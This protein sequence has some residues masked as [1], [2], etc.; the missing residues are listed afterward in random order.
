MAQS[1]PNPVP[2]AGPVSTEVKDIL[3]SI[4]TKK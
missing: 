4:K 1:F 3:E 2:P